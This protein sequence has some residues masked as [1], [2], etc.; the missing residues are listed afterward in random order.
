MCL[1]VLATLVS[2]V[3]VRY[4]VK[5]AHKNPHPTTRDV[6]KI[7][8]HLLLFSRYFL[9]SV[10]SKISL[11]YRIATLSFTATSDGVRTTTTTLCASLLFPCE[12]LRQR[13]Q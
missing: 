3:A 8:D 12:I 7:S 9:F 10:A 11:P 1:Y 4:H 5:F 6:V 13:Q 2:P